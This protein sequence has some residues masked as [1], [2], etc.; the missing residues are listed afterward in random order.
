[1]PHHLILLIV[2]IVLSILPAEKFETVVDRFTTID[3]VI[4]R[5]TPLTKTGGG[6]ISQDGISSLPYCDDLGEGDSLPP[7]GG[8]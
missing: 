4:C 1:M 5:L 2:L 3:G 7:H 6:V 8:L